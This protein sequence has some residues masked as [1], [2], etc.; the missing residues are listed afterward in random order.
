MSI[1]NVISSETMNPTSLLSPT[2]GNV[3]M[4]LNVLYTPSLLLH[5]PNLPLLNGQFV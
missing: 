1:P 3:L 2:S 4:L 5:T